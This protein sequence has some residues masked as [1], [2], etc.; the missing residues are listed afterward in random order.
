MPAQP[1][2]MLSTLYKKSATGALE[3]W[4][5]GT[6][7]NVI[8]TRWGQVGGAVQETRD[9]VKKGKNEGR[10]NATTP[11]QQ[12]E[13]EAK[14]KWE[15]KLKKGYVKTKKDAEA[16]EV[17]SIIE[18]GIFPMLAHKFA[19]QGHKLKYPC[20]IQP[21]L[22]GHRCIA[23]TDENC[24]ASLWSRTRKRI[25]SMTHIEAAIE[26]LRLPNIFL[27]GEL[28]NHEF[29]DRFED[30]S[31]FIRNSEFQPGAEQLQY[32]IYDLPSSWGFGQRWDFLM[33]HLSSVRDPLRLVET[34]S[35]QDEDDLMNGFNHYLA[36]GY[37]GAMA[38]NVDGPYVNKRSTN[39]LKIKEFD[40]AE[41]E[42]IG[43]EEGRGKLAGHA[44]FVCRAA[45]GNEFRAKLKGKQEDLKQYFD[46]PGL[47]IGRQLTVKYQGLT[48]K[49]QVPRFPVAWRFREDL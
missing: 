31:S 14:S 35:V 39:L 47:A 33:N 20:R 48:N 46:N 19:E 17:D 28:Y 1:L 15:K 12:A 45:N 34:Y 32:H 30:L 29:R 13:L 41:F 24:K 10:A 4:A 3:E 16:G 36:Q 6:Q 49:A 11:V 43:V 37:E 25:T 27:D 23:T 38:R 44:I 42:V 18:G 21:K 5:I 40:D 22:D 26:A 8:V 2:K 9:E 7:G